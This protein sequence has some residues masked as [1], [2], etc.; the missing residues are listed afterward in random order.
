EFFDGS[1]SL[2]VASFSSKTLTTTLAPGTHSI[3]A[4]Y[5]G[6][7]TH[8]PSTSSVLTQ[9]VRPFATN[10]S[11]TSSLN[12]SVFGQPVTFTATVTSSNGTPTGSVQFLDF[13]NLLGTVNLSAGSASLTT[14]TL[15]GGGHE[16]RVQYLG[17]GMFGGSVAT[18]NQAVGVITPVGSN[19]AVQET[20]GA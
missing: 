7:A 13:A 15:T 10:T 16:I 4:S 3:T 20:L 14:S 9:I 8:L 17:D 2:G 18:L 11:L 19:V 12:P 6:D 5:R 1:V